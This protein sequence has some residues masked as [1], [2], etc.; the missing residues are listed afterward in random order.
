MK[1]LYVPLSTFK[2]WVKNYRLWFTV[3][4]TTAQHDIAVLSGYR[5]W[6]EV[7]VVNKKTTMED[8]RGFHPWGSNDIQGLNGVLKYNTTCSPYNY[9]RLLM[10]AYQYMVSHQEKKHS[11]YVRATSFIN[12]LSPEILVDSTRIDHRLENGDLVIL[13][14]DIFQVVVRGAF[15]GITPAF[16]PAKE[17]RTL[18][19]AIIDMCRELDENTLWGNRREHALMVFARAVH[20]R[21]IAM[22]SMISLGSFLNEVT[23]INAIRSLVKYDDSYGCDGVI[24]YLQSIGVYDGPSSNTVK[25][26]LVSKIKEDSNKQGLHICQAEISK[27][28]KDLEKDMEEN[29]KIQ[30]SYTT[31]RNDKFYADKT[32]CF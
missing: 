32:L 26:Y 4:H 30:H 25:E 18:L 20:N 15:F 1:R 27:K 17:A 5:D 14:N 21:N 19:S 2:V 7:C 28:L 22:S 24:G 23:D 8:S 6:S 11:S 3:K 10:F 12:G 31:T 9:A 29:S 13:K 16:T